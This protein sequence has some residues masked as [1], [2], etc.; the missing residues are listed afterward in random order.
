MEAGLLLMALMAGSPVSD[1]APRSGGVRA[2]AVASA[3]IISAE[4]VSVNENMEQFD[5]R[6]D[7]GSKPQL[8]R[9]VNENAQYGGQKM[10][11]TEFH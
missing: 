10:I 4:S 8:L 3:R 11:V 5:Y 6:S 2:Q 1:V 7:S 9:T